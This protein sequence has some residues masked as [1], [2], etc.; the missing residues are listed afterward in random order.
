MFKKKSQQK[1]DTAQE[2][3]GH[4]GGGDH[5]PPA[6]HPRDCPTEHR[7]QV[8]VT[9]TYIHMHTH[10]GPPRQEGPPRLPAAPGPPHLPRAHH[11]GD[12]WLLRP[13]HAILWAPRGAMRAGHRAGPADG[14]AGSDVGAQAASGGPG[15]AP[16][17]SGLPEA[18][19]QREG[20]RG[21]EAQQTHHSHRA[22]GQAAD[23]TPRPAGTETFKSRRRGTQEQ[24]GRRRGAGVLRCPEDESTRGSPAGHRPGCPPGASQ[25][26]TPMALRPLPGGGT[27]GCKDAVGR[28]LLGPGRVVQFWL[29]TGSRAS[30]PAAPLWPALASSGLPRQQAVAADGTCFQ[31]SMQPQRGGTQTRRSRRRPSCSSAD[32]RAGSRAAGALALREGRRS[33]DP[34]GPWS[35]PQ[36]LVDM[37]HNQA[38]N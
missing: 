35:P 7:T 9:S 4:G 29:D 34:E 17:L 20:P 14:Q 2:A 18:G 37:V 31:D 30:C 22:P 1:Q 16:V 27:S 38:F 15:P 3:A 12:K 25:V 23:G 6:V 21:G 10:G 19:G 36:I 33:P 11:P 26:S 5:C 24:G 13:G 32:G 8:T 28:R